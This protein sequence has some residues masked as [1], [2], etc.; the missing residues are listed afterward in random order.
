MTLI[1]SNIQRRTLYQINTSKF[2]RAQC[3]AI[4]WKRKKQNLYS[5]YTL[6]FLIYLFLIV[7]KSITT[8]KNY[9]A[10]MRPKLLF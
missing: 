2:F 3:S 7:V 1:F 4:S 5:D 8:G 10:E 6:Y 9:N